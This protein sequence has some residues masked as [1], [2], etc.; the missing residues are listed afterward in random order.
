MT[1]VSVVLTGVQLARHDLARCVVPG[2]HSRRRSARSG[3]VDGS[4]TDAAV[5]AGPSPVEMAE[6]SN[7]LGDVQWI[8]SETTLRARAL[9]SSS[10]DDLLSP[11]AW[12][13][14]DRTPRIR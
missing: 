1:F 2:R 5:D 11:K 10:M 9:R 8:L 14:S 3:F 12:G 7:F 6:F 13:S 4:D